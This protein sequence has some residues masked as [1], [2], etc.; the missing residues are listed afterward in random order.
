MITVQKALEIANQRNGKGDRVPFS[1]EFVKF[2]ESTKEGGEL[3][4]LDSVVKCG[5]KKGIDDKHLIGIRTV[6]NSHHDYTVHINLITNI[7]GQRV[8]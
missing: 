6:N 5:L 4:Q 1:I 8:I 2:S 3:L 7:N